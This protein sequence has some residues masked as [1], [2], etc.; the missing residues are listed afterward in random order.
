[1]EGLTMRLT[2]RLCAALL[3]ASSA[4]ARA[5]DTRA[6]TLRAPASRTPV[7]AE[8]AMKGD[9][10]AVRKLVQAGTDVNVAQGD[11]MT[12]LH[13]AAEY[14]R[15]EAIRALLKHGADPKVHSNAMNVTEQTAR[16]QAAAKKRYEVL[17]AYL[18]QAVR[19]SLA[20]ARVRDSITAAQNP[21]PFRGGG[22]GGRQALPNWPFTPAQ[23][24]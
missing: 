11:G 10:A 9:D 12:A 18:P 16:E 13:W 1:P 21:A 15:P 5:Q 17:V 8:A 2:C 7:V 24:Q 22:G 6:T 23:F 20:A 19:D 14:D 3:I 4:A